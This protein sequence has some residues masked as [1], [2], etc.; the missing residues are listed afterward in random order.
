[1]NKNY[2]KSIFNISFGHFKTSNLL[3][4]KINYCIYAIRMNLGIFPSYSRVNR[5]KVNDIESWV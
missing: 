5:K 4:Y 2:S 3:V 1:M